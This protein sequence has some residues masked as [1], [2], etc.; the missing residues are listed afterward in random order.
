MIFVF[1]N[2]FCDDTFSGKVKSIGVSNFSVKNL[3]ILLDSKPKVIPAVNQVELHPCL[4][5]EELKNYCDSKDDPTRPKIHLTAY[6]PIGMY[7]VGIPGRCKPL[8]MPPF[9]RLTCFYFYLAGQLN[10]DVLLENENILEIAARLESTPG[11]VVLAW[12]VHRGTS[13]VPKSANEDRMT[14]NI[15][16]CGFKILT[17]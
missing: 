14:R 2:L 10:K 16:V 15:N 11:Q 13:I 6:S 1:D 17:P 7:R 3:Q 9:F 8:H 4:P 12:G 5:Q